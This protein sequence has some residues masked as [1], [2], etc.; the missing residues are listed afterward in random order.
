MVYLPTFIWKPRFGFFR[1]I[2]AST[3]VVNRR[4][5][6]RRMR[7]RIALPYRRARGAR[8]ALRAIRQEA[9]LDRTDRV[10]DGRQEGSL[11]GSHEPL[12]LARLRVLDRDPGLAI[13]GAGIDRVARHGLVRSDA[14]RG[15]TLST[16][17]L[18]GR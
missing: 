7:V 10:A 18:G 5:R 13:R 4:A 8:Q 12:G 1:C 16:H 15:E 14:R 2:R 9:G 11:D 17:P 6:P 3:V